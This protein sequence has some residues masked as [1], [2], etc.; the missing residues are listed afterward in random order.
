MAFIL[1]R[2]VL[3]QVISAFLLG[4]FALTGMIFVGMAGGMMRQDF[5]IVQ[6]LAVWPYLVLYAL[7][8]ALPVA[9]LC[10]VVLVFGRLGADNEITAARSSGVAPERL[11]LPVVLLSVALSAGSFWMYQWALPTAHRR[12]DQHKE[13]MLKMAMESLGV[14][15]TRFHAPPY[16]IYVRTKDPTTQEWLDVVIVQL[17]GRL[18]R[19]VL[20]ADRGVCR[21]D[22]ESERALITLKNC[23]VLEPEQNSAGAAVFDRWLHTGVAGAG[24]DFHGAVTLG[25]STLRIPVDLSILERRD[26]ARAAL[27]GFHD[28]REHLRKMAE[29]LRDAPPVRRPRTTHRTLSRQIKGLRLVAQTQDRARAEEQRRL[30]KLRGERKELDQRI[31]TATDTVNALA[32]RQR[33]FGE[34]E[35]DLKAKLAARPPPRKKGAAAIRRELADL[36]RA[37]RLLNSRLK[38]EKDQIREMRSASGKADAAARSQSAALAKVTA[39]LAESRRKLAELAPKV[40][41]ADRH[42]TYLEGVVEYHSRNAA[43]ATCLVFTL[44]GIPLGILSH[45]GNVM[46]AL[47][48]SMGVILIVYYPLNMIAQMLG[49]DGYVPVAAAFWTPNV[50][51]AAIGVALQAFAVRR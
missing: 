46:Y 37:Q 16:L 42:E 51:V 4:L 1:E 27:K 47:A 35:R 41:N 12:V 19:R 14:A 36:T 39:E 44:V 33:E 2:Y 23:V 30:D 6:V 31:L 28:L 8:F 13:L 45:R 7:P 11:A 34:K 48:L 21:V 18:V 49:V 24:R 40:A 3:R 10:A 50:V 25:P 22:Q 26:P 17:D 9:F 20:R 43:A 32:E 29:E 5:D 38:S 15:V